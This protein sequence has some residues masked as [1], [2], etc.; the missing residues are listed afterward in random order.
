[1]TQHVSEPT[2]IHGNTLDLVVT[3]ADLQPL[4]V[5]VEP[6]GMF[7]DHT[8]VICR[9]PLDVEPISVAEKLV[10]GWRC[11]DRAELRRVLEDSELCRPPPDDAD[12]DQLFTTYDT[13][14]RDVADHLAPLRSVRRQRGRLSPWFDAECR[15][16]RRDC[17]RL[18]RRYRRTRTLADRRL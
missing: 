15:W 6:A 5:D 12:V 7:S 18:E 16:A 4:T 14:L 9:L 2:Q 13:V 11:V 17:R 1:M 8:L 3:P 10:R